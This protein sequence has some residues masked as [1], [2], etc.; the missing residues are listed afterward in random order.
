MPTYFKNFDSLRFY[1]FLLVF[2][3]H[4][5][6][7]FS[8]QTMPF[9][10]VI[11]YLNFGDI[12]VLFF[13]VLSGFLITTL[14]LR[15][16]AE[17]NINI[18]F[19]YLRRIKRIWPVYFIVV[20]TRYLILPGMILFLAYLGVS[21]G[22][23][24]FTPVPLETLPWFLFFGAN[25]YLSYYSFLSPILNV[26]WS[27]SIEEQ[28]YAFWPLLVKFFKGIVIIPLLILIIFLSA[29]FRYKVHGTPSEDFH[30]ISALMPL[31]IGAL[32]SYITFFY[33]KIL[34][35]FQ[36]LAKF[37]W[38]TVYLLTVLFFLLRI[39]RDDLSFSFPILSSLVSLFL[40]LMFALLIMEQ[41]VAK[42]AIWQ[43]G[44]S[45][46]ISYLGKISYG[47]YAYHMIAFTLVLALL[48][49]SGLSVNIIYYCFAIVSAFF[50][51]I[52]MAA[53]SYKYIEKP[54]LAK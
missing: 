3:G 53:V 18:K 46:L 30:T 34:L 14:L 36:N 39:F 41:G 4:V 50:V 7:G 25:F 45:R 23:N 26:L 38:A 33:H 35:S 27:V 51:T 19:F 11:P 1:A 54:I 24:S 21:I 37:W 6:T 29:Y 16:K 20:L 47:L 42:N 2:I 9:Y 40:S 8:F 28:F 48:R 44:N 52:L 22:S 31:G 49:L 12:G 15:E 32:F 43:A 5:F 13:F 10:S 17:K